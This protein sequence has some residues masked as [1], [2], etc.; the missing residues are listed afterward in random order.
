MS[1]RTLASLLT[2]VAVASGCATPNPHVELPRAPAPDEPFEER[3]KYYKAHALQ[4]VEYDH[5]FLHGGTRVYWPE[6]LLPAVDAESATAKAIQDHVVARER[7]EAWRWLESTSSGLVGLGLIGMGA[8][9]GF[10]LVPIA[11]PQ[12]DDLSYTLAIGSLVGGGAV[13]LLGFSVLL[14]YGIIVDE[15]AKAAGEASDRTT[16]TYP[17]S[18]SDRL[19]VG[20]DANGLI[21]DYVKPG[22]PAPAPVDED[23]GRD[24]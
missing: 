16:K 13:T 8:S 23:S 20:V 18:L 10:V 24:I 11:A 9:L 1:R 6:D 15:D 4:T 22:A 17:Q 21:Q 12:L 5:L 2:L 7:V 19:G 14:G 3:A